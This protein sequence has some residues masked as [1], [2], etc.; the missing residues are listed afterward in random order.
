MWENGIFVKPDR[1]LLQ[2][3]MRFESWDGQSKVM[4]SKKLLNKW[5]G[6][7]A[8]EGKKKKKETDAIHVRLLI[9]QKLQIYHRVQ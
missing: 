3:Y 4:V 5:K 7:H 9:C 1:E 8:R 2:A 6:M